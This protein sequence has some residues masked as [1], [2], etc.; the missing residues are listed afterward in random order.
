MNLL[1]LPKMPMAPR[2]TPDA[3]GTADDPDTDFQSAYSISLHESYGE[4]YCDSKAITVVSED[5][6]NDNSVKHAK[7][8]QII[9]V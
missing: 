7:L 2:P 9:K 8:P 4:S 5:D 1:P 6:P 3:S